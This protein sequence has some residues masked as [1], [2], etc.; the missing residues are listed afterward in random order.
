MRRVLLLL[1]GGAGLGATLGRSARKVAE[2]PSEV[3]GTVSALRSLDKTAFAANAA[4][5]VQGYYAPGDGGGGV[6]YLDRSDAVTPD[7]GGT[8]IAPDTGR[9]R[10]CRVLNGFISPEMFGARGDGTSDDYG[11]FKALAAYV[12]AGGCPQ[13]VFSPHKIYYWDQYVDG[14]H[15]PVTDIEFIGVNGLDLDGAGSTILVKGSFNRSA[16]DIRSLNGLVLIRCHNA[17]VRNLVL[18]GNS[19]TITKSKGVNEPNSDGVFLGSCANILLQNIISRDWTCDGFYISCAS[20]PRNPFIAS[21]QVTMLN[22]VA[23]ENARQGMSIIQLRGGLFADCAF[24]NTGRSAYGNHAPSAGVDIEPDY[25]TGGEPPYQMDLNTGELTFTRCRFIHNLGMAMVGGG[26]SV[27]SVTCENCYFDTTGARAYAFQIAGVNFAVRDSYFNCGD[28]A[29]YDLLSPPLPGGS[30][31]FAHN[32]VHGTGTLLYSAAGAYPVTIR[33]CR[34]FMDEKTPSH[35][36]ALYLTNPDIFFQH[37][38]LFIDKAGYIAGTGGY[39]VK[40][41]INGRSRDNLY[42]TNLKASACPGDTAHYALGIYSPAAVLQDETF[43]GTNP[44][45]ADTFRPLYNGSWDTRMPFSWTG[46]SPAR[47]NEPGKPATSSAHGE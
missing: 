19:Q 46:A 47:A 4:V 38:Y 30:L 2:P 11:A 14:S 41:L 9:G 7:N 23:D 28:A 33:D 39:E 20:S 45:R 3:L 18:D 13:I 15:S 27:D 42:E 6:F 43:R 17:T 1:A 35:L 5:T 32:E 22:C 24:S 36:Y 37:N 8:V 29:I 12:S 25:A 34:F 10:W 44:G 31:L 26:G 21:S 40:T 16:R